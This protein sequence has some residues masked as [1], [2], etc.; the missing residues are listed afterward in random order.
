MD[1]RHTHTQT[2][3]QQSDTA[4][5]DTQRQVM[6]TAV[7]GDRELTLS[8]EDREECDARSDLADDGLDLGPD[9]FLR[10]ERL[11]V[12]RVKRSST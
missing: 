8:L 7:R 9:L 1:E 11:A 4:R 12:K 2:K 6:S 5:N 10:L 3:K